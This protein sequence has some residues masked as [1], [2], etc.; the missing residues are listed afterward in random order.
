M[1]TSISVMRTRAAVSSQLPNGGGGDVSGCS[2]LESGGGVDT[3]S[4]PCGG[5]LSV[6]CGGVL[7]VLCG[8]EESLSAVWVPLLFVPCC[9][10][11]VSLLA[12]PAVTSP[13]NP[14]ASPHVTTLAHWLLRAIFIAVP[15]C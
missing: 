3:L 2:E 12:H 15:F 9:A 13:A 4:V 1:P 7:P 10:S 6:L 11:S 5:A 8:C 14:H